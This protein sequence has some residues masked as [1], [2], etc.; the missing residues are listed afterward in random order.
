MYVGLDLGHVVC[1]VVQGEGDVGVVGVG[2]ARGEQAM[3]IPQTGCH[4]H[5]FLRRIAIDYQVTG[6]ARVG[7]DFG[8]ALDD[9]EGHLT[10]FQFARDL[11]ADPPKTA[12]DVVVAQLLDFQL[13]P[14]DVEPAPQ[15]A[16]KCLLHD[17]RQRVENRANAY[18]DET[19]GEEL[20]NG[21]EGLQFTEPDG[22]EGRDGLVERVHQSHSREQHVAA[23]A[24]CD[25]GDE[26]TERCTKTPTQGECTKQ[27]AMH[28]PSIIG[29]AR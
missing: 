6:G 15:I 13:H 12:E 24:D 8:R 29:T 19:D 17:E 20:L 16:F 4:E 18:Q 27:V 21:A 5:V 28:A 3:R 9:Y 10:L 7:G 11:V 1:D 2:V 22:A 26:E 14:P 25:R 23:S